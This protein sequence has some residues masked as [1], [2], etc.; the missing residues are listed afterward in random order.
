[1]SPELESLFV[2]TPS[3]EKNTIFLRLEHKPCLEKAEIIASFKLGASW[4]F[5]GAAISKNLIT[6][7]FV[8]EIDV[9]YINYVLFGD[10]LVCRSIVQNS[11]KID[12]FH[13]LL[14]YFLQ[15]VVQNILDEPFTCCF[16][17]T[18][19]IVRDIV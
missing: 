12:Q 18:C 6:G 14:N 11:N 15:K 13:F 7:R 4:L 1:M 3:E 19:A 9:N 10:A 17:F 8:F 16:I 5:S 2:D